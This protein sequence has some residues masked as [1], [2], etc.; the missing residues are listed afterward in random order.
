MTK[1]F[2]TEE[3]RDIAYHKDEDL[4]GQERTTK[5]GDVANRLL[6]LYGRRLRA[7]FPHVATPR[8]IRN[9]RNLPLYYLIWAG[10]HELGLKGA[11]HILRQGEKIKKRR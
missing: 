1:C 6:E 7:I 11:N 10:P 8:L 9:T 2:G 4:F 3:W 5:H